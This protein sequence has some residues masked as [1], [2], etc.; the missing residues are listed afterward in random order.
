MSR[1]EKQDIY[2]Q[3]ELLSEFSSTEVSSTVTWYITFM[4][5]L[6][7]IVVKEK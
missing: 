2:E 1:L 4:S 6:E 7:D 3:F 5:E